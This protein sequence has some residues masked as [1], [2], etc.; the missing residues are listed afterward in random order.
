MT[1]FIR[2]QLVL[3]LASAVAVPAPSQTQGGVDILLAKARSL[4]LRGRIDLAAENWHKVLLVNPNQ[5]EALA[6]LARA[7]KENG[8][9]DEERS[10]VDRLRKI[11]PHDGEIAAVEKLHVFTPEERNR[12][13]EAGRLAMQ[14]KPD[15]AMKIYRE[16]LGD[17]PP[18]LGKW[19]QPYYETEAASTGGSAKAISQLRQLCAQNPN[20][21][22]YRLWL[23]S[24]L[25]YDPKTRMEGLQM[26]ASIKDPSA[27][28]Q[29][30]APWRQALLWEKENPEV[31]APMEAY[32]QRYP[33]QDLQPIVVALQAKQQE[34]VADADK[35]LA[36]KALRNKDI[37]TAAARFTEVLRQSPNDANATIGLGYV[38]LD[39]KRFSDA[40]SLFDKA[41]T[42]APQRQD[43]RDGYDS[44]RF[45]LAMERGADGQRLN[46]A[47]VAVMAYQEALSLRPM[48]NGALLGL[49]HALVRQHKFAD[50][51]ARFQQVLNQDPH[52]ADAMAGLGF[53]RLNEGRFG[54]ASRLL[55]NA[56]KLDPSRKDVDQ[57]Y[58]NAKFW[59]VMNQAAEDLKRNQVAKAVDA[60][61]QAL[62]LNP[63]NKDALVG[64]ANASLRAD[65]FPSAAKT[66][67]RLAAS[68]PSDESSWLGLINAQIG[69]NAPQAAISTLQQIPATVKQK[70]ET[71]SD[72]L[73]EI[74]LAYDEA[75]QPDSGDQFL[76]RAML[77]AGRFDSDE[78]LGLRLQIAGRFMEQ[79][80]AGRAIEIY[81][82]A[83]RSHPDNPSGWEGLVGAYTRLGVFAQAIDTVRSMPRLS[84]NAAMKHTGFL[85]SVAVL[86]SNQGQC[87]EAE[88]FLLQSL[89]LDR[90]KG[91][92][93]SE[94][95]QLQLADIWM[96]EHNYDGARALLS[97]IVLV[98][99]NSADA[100]RGYLAVLHQQGADRTLVGEIAN[101]PAPVRTQLE[102][103]PNFLI[104]EA[105]AY[106]NSGRNQDALQLLQEARS[107]YAAKRRLPPMVLDIQT[108]WTMLA[109]SVDAPGLGD[110]L[111]NDKRRADLTVKERGV[112][113][114]IYSDW[115]VRR[116]ERAFA[117]KPELA[118]SILTDAGREYPKDRDINAEQGSLYLREHDKLKALDLFEAWGMVG[119]QAG[120]YRVAAGAA[121][122][123][124]KFNLADQYLRRGLAKF[125]HDPEL[126]HMT[127]RQDIARGNYDEG[128]QELKSALE[129]MHDQN[130]FAPKA[131]PAT[132]GA[133]S[134]TVDDGSL[135]THGNSSDA[136]GSTGSAPPCRTEASRGA[137][138][139][140]RI[141]P[142]SLVF[143]VSHGHRTYL[144][145]AAFQESQRQEPPQPQ[146]QS[147][148]EQGQPQ[149]QPQPQQAQQLQSQQPQ[150]QEKEQQVEDEV[151][152]VDDRNTPLVSVGTVGTGR[153]G[154][155]GIDRLIVTDSL[156][157]SA[158][159]VS[160]QVRFGV[161]GHG[162][163]ALSGTPDGSSKLLFGTLPAGAMFGDQSKTGYSALGQISTNTFGMAFG[164]SP[165][166]FAVHNLIGGLRYRP[167]GGWLS[168]EGVRD[169][170]KDSLLSYAGSRDPGTDMR[171]GGVVA[172]TATV[173]LDTAPPTPHNSVYKTI[174][175][176]ASG[177][178]S[179][180]QGL[181]V[182]H[183]WS[184]SG[185]AGLYW[186]IV[187][188]LTLGANA[189]AMHYD[190]NLKYFSFGQGGYF[191]PQQYYLASIPISW[192]SRHPRFEYEVKFSGGVQYLQEDA[193]PFYPVSPGTA[194]VKQGTYASDSSAG[195][196]YD[197]DARM[198]YRVAPHVYLGTFATANNSRDYYT[199]SAGFSLK[200]MMDPIP[201]NTDLQVNSIPDWT[202][203]QPF[204]VH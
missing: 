115:S 152:A 46:Q 95:T 54:D 48:D 16:V 186:Q 172:N 22:A 39:Q 21:E 130:T 68:E 200:F 173:R 83:T 87:A 180:V 175:G 146:P 79:N 91:N 138:N 192:Y 72:Y 160:N 52:N 157:G 169:S 193:S 124:H 204:S 11:N 41:R 117:T 31:L 71:R 149:Q 59:G 135:S 108:A 165:Q 9:T 15:D 36:F 20:V 45:W 53:V 143:S 137:T 7:A 123:A 116:A 141:R 109:V 153:L 13:D 164:T 158:Y 92:Q 162:I 156:L 147:V 67:Y 140:G 126:M 23:A 14:H 145:Y 179:F 75:N 26:F 62:G 112:L 43:A 84:Y 44:A 89:A 113:E 170:V 198:G 155:S 174:G 132:M 28:E 73:S 121:L 131:A 70:L 125:P 49:A 63:N 78:A 58:N 103:D 136:A 88:H 50:A 197:A 201:T 119:A 37:E 161:E 12:L 202:G 199:Q 80:Q 102:T 1:R 122:S 27:A 168:I 127:A 69:E 3:I 171:W 195:P 187:Q 24:L 8:Q 51:E 74:A 151:E 185:N 182:P 178:Y 104:L 85:D 114:A 196:N 106:S 94:G 2:F 76:H 154:D 81:R 77:I 142:T 159:T 134:T 129:A 177:S 111:L 139:E 166:G 47:E 133:D 148:Q 65:D 4:E 40:L 10:Y 188:G 128:E 33:D 6:G 194:T 60:Y 55:A 93:S 105:T 99:A 144:R 64:L 96:R 163:Y 29:A 66:Y 38:R 30:R 107:R 56:H 42:L 86:Y 35:E 184:I 120:D 97:N 181:N 176:Y 167:A 101:I 57:G 32:L 118:F 90:S 203:H 150:Q 5:T 19:T 98:N 189:S 110:L 191:S 25:T 18:P 61:Q 17:Q 190:R 183:N 100:W 82:E 34:N